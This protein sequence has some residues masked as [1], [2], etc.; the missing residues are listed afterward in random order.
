MNPH[1]GSH[2]ALANGVASDAMVFLT[3]Q[4]SNEVVRVGESLES[5]EKGVIAIVG[6]LNHDFQ[7]MDR[8]INASMCA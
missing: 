4:T 3:V 2:V 8:P 1:C 6:E 7:M 5:A